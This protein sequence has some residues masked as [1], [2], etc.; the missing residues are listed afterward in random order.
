MKTPDQLSQTGVPRTSQTEDP[1]WPWQCVT[2]PGDWPTPAQ[3]ALPA[4]QATTVLGE[5]MWPGYRAN[6]R[7]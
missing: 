3:A 1:L 6:G 4:A 5:E 7:Q 2:L